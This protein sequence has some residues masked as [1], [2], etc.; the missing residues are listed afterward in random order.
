MQEC[1]RKWRSSGTRPPSKGE[2]QCGT[3]WREHMKDASPEHARLFGLKERK[4]LGYQFVQ[5]A[6]S[7]IIVFAR[8]PI[9]ESQSKLSIVFWTS[10]GPMQAASSATTP[11]SDLGSETS[12]LSQPTKSWSMSVPSSFLRHSLLLRRLPPIRK[13]APLSSLSSDQD[14][15]VLGL[16]L[17]SWRLAYELQRPFLHSYGYRDC[18]FHSLH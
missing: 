15:L 7:S 18:R 4:D 3:E 16:H 10:S 2:Y 5:Y 17:T 11:L 6:I 8:A 9:Y 13:P 14:L 12:C 1:R